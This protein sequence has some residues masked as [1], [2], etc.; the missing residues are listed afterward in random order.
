MRSIGRQSAL[1]VVLAAGLGGGAFVR[2]AWLAALLL[3][4]LAALWLALGERPRRERWVGGAAFLL[5]AAL[6]MAGAALALRES[7]AMP[8]AEVAEAAR[9]ASAAWWR[10]LELDATRAAESLA[11]V[12]LPGDSAAA[13]F[14]ALE[15]RVLATPGRSYFL[16][17]PLGEPAAW[18]GAGLLH[19]LSAARLPASGPGFLQS[20]TSASALAVAP[21]AGAPGWRLVAGESR[22]R[23]AGP[24]LGG[25]AARLWERSAWAFEPAAGPGAPPELRLESPP[26]RH[27]RPAPGLLLRLAAA[28]AGGGWFVLA[29]LRAIGL[30]LLERTV[31]PR[32]RPPVEVAAVAAVGLTALAAAAGASPP[33]AGLLGLALLL[34][35]AGWAVGSA[36]RGGIPALAVAASAGPAA[37]GLA[38]LPPLSGL[39]LASSLAGGPDALALRVALL[40]ATFGAVAS[41]AKARAARLAEGALWLAI[42]VTLAAAV[43]AD[44]TPLAL[45]AAALAGLGAALWCSPVRLRR[46]P[47][48]AVVALLAG[49]IAAAGWTAGSRLQLRQEAERRVGALLPPAAAELEALAEATKRAL[50]GAGYLIGGGETRTE[51]GDL[52]FA[53]WRQSPLARADLLSA[54]IVERPGRAPSTFAYGLPL[55]DRFELDLAPA[56]WVDLAPPAW[57]ARAISGRVELQRSVVVRFWAVPRPGFGPAATPVTD[58]AAGLLRGGPGVRR[59]GPALPEPLAWVGY[60]PA[61]EVVWSPWKTGTPARTSFE[62]HAGP[63]GAAVATPAGRARF[64]FA[65]AEAGAAAVLVPPL[66]PIAACERAGMTAAGGLAAAAGLA[67]LGALAALPR[68]ATRDLVRRTVRSYSKR[69]VLV[70]TLLLLV[71]LALLYAL[72]SQSLGRRVE[73]QQQAE[74]EAALVSAQRVLGE[75]VLSLE[76]G[77][78]LGTAIDDELLVWLSR[79]VQH[80]VSL[81]WGSEVYASSKRDL[82]TAGLLPRRIPGEIWSRVALHG[83]GLV[84]RTGRAGG[85]E[86][87]ELYAPLEIPGT[88][89][90]S[91]RLFLAMPLLAQQ[92]E[93]VL[94]TGRIRRRALLATL[95]LFLVLAATGTRLAAS[96][97]RPIDD[98]VAGTRRIAAGAA[99]LE[100]QPAELELEALAEAID[101]MAG[102]IAE[103]RE[104][105]LGEK[106][107]VERIVENVTAGVVCLDRAGCVL[108][109]NRAARELLAAVPGERLAERVAGTP[110]LAPVGAFLAGRGAFGARADVRLPDPAGE[111]EWTL[112]WAPLEGPGEP[113]AL[114]VIEDVTEIA[115]GQRLDAWAS[116][117]RIIAH[118]IKNP[119][120]PIRLS[121]EHLRE[122]WTRDREH[123]AAVFDRCTDNI[124]RQVDELRG[125]ASEFSTYSHVPRLERAPGDLAAAVREVVEAYRAAPPP[126]V[127]VRLAGAD[128]ALPARFDAKL[129]PRALRNLLENAL[130]A[131]A[132]RGEVEVRLERSGGSARIAVADR[133][134]GVAPEQLERIFEPYFSTHAGGTG[135]GL[136]IAR[137]IAE[138]HGGTLAARN[139]PSGGL[140]AVIT[141]PVE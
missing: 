4:L 106:L 105:L 54:L 80:E 136:P 44:R 63:D 86:Y 15:R 47:S 19:R 31:F 14:A 124:L 52:A 60:D 62:G 28:V 79:V 69:L 58:L 26:A 78:G 11:G 66:S 59:G 48:V 9:E 104:R 51:S 85:A 90:G 40:A 37:A 10:A 95:T 68:P 113:E 91:T 82:F 139:R 111:R 89:R 21:V 131:S 135:L 29:V 1:E 119:L 72:L 13:A 114:L 102:R 12:P 64:A 30:A 5:A 76:P 134:P 100:F 88:P 96:F 50:G 33:V 3:T 112:I 67:L 132:G 46:L 41:A 38:L 94:E 127:A 57:R 116:M 56:R 25:P 120:T 110:R 107:L 92:E 35:A 6:A 130:R 23:D 97:T 55:D 16:L 53:L 118:E 84:A 17:D 81:Y 24:P 87:V 141:I 42:G 109:A 83:D 108:L 71:P 34:A 101:R 49:L 39:D 45:A 117:A 36:G 93:A 74:A 121:A 122:V 27:A 126:G 65:A 115:R 70:F 8:A 2:P 125:I 128:E 75:Y 99:R 18:A 138:E 129:L 77:F 73:R 98:L 43:A 133:G 7:A 140:E 20:A 137:R 32:R 103:G 123:F 61:G 22:G